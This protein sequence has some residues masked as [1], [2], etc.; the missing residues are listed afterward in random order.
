MLWQDRVLVLAPLSKGW[1][2]A[3]TAERVVTQLSAA[4]FAAELRDPREIE[5]TVHEPQRDSQFTTDTDCD[6]RWDGVGAVIAFHALR[7]GH[8]LSHMPATRAARKAAGLPACAIVFGGTDVNEAWSEEDNRT[9]DAAVLR[10]DA[11][12]CFNEAMRSRATA[13]WPAWQGSIG[14]RMI[15]PSVPQ[16]V[17]GP[18]G[19]SEMM[20]AVGMEWNSASPVVLLVSGIRAVKDPLFAVQATMSDRWKKLQGPPQLV[21]VGP[22]RG[23]VYDTQFKEALGEA[24]LVWYVPAVAQVVVHRAMMQATAIINV[25][26]SEGASNAILEAMALARPIVARNIPGNISLLQHGETGL[27]FDTEE[28][29]VDSIGKIVAEPDVAQRLG[30]AARIRFEAVHKLEGESNAY[31]ELTKDLLLS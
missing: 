9:M 31:V 12:V 7:S 2:N 14:C 29:F 19:L 24:P 23:G 16:P 11:F 30:N 18:Q 20:D 27:L 3:I 13:R 25:S 26:K 4:G 5:D 28:E 15:P 10:A 8:L 21:I 6:T 1:G 22:G 17:G